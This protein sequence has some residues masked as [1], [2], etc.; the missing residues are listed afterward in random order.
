MECTYYILAYN[1]YTID[2]ILH[3]HHPPILPPPSLQGISPGTFPRRFVL[4]ADTITHDSC[5]E[6]KCPDVTE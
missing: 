4:G 5:S 2:N 3:T 1:L 6:Y